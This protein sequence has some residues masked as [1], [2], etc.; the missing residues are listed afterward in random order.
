MIE[1]FVKSV[2]GTAGEALE[3]RAY[4]QMV[5][6]YKDPGV[7]K[8]IVAAELAAAGESW[9]S[10]STY[11]RVKAKIQNNEISFVRAAKEAKSGAHEVLRET[12]IYSA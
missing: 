3:N 1:N 4:R 8:A 10:L 12:G 11:V 7:V 5:K 6:R 2:S 9:E